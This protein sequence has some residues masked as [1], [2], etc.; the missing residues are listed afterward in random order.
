LTQVADH[1]NKKYGASIDK[2]AKTI[3]ANLNRISTSFY[4]LRKS[5]GGGLD[6]AFQVNKKMSFFADWLM[7]VSENFSHLN[8]S[9]KQILLG[10]GFLLG[11]I[12]PFT[13]ALGATV[14]MLGYA[15]TGVRMLLL[16]LA[17]LRFAMLGISAAMTANPLGIFLLVTAGIL[18]FW[19]DI[20]K[21]VEKTID[22]LGEF[23]HFGKDVKIVSGF[24]FDKLK[25]TFNFGNDNNN[26]SAN[27]RSSVINNSS[28]HRNNVITNNKKHIT[29]NVNVNITGSETPVDIG[30]IENS[31]RSIFEEENRKTYFEIA[32]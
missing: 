14:R 28:N 16:P 1:I 9:G 26:P 18:F 20:V 31:V 23:K 24:L 12:G 8:K 25:S 22:L 3:R 29:N 4:F 13:L 19:N 30:L 5:I 7:L 6:E 27:V 2:G 15:L 21:A 32:Q 11:V 17:A 10:F